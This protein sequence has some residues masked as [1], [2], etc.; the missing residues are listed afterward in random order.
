MGERANSLNWQLGVN[1]SFNVTKTTRLQL[2]ANYVGPSVS[3]QGQ[4]NAYFYMNVS[5]RQ[6]FFKRKLSATLALRDVLCTARFKNH[7]SAVNLES[8]TAVRPYSPMVTLSLSYIF[9]DF[10]QKKRES[11]DSDD[12]FEGSKH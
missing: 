10:T 8:I 1:N 12:L 9:N 5:A 4:V 11:T 7:V 2:D 6:Q 3:T